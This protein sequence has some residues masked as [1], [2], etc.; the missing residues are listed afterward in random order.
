MEI[1]IPV[2][3]I[4]IITLLGFLSPLAI[5]LANQP[6]WPSRQKKA[7]SIVIALLLAAIALILYY[8]ISGDAVPSWP[9]LILLALVVSQ[10]S[11]TLVLKTPATAIEEASSPRRAPRYFSDGHNS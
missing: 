4:G 11:Y 1:Q 3:P 6:W 8:L 7:V 10:A 5:A 9:V 2:L